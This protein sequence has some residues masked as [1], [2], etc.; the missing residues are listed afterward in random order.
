MTPEETK[1][2]L[3]S[4]KDYKQRVEYI[5][6]K[7]LNVHSYDFKAVKASNAPHKNQNDYIVMKDKYLNKMHEIIKNI[8]LLENMKHRSV[9]FY[10]Y[11]ELMNAYEVADLIGCSVASVYAYLRESIK[12]LG[13]ILTEPL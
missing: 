8:E 12:E 10:R 6:N 5:E 11:I 13:K 1:T 3:E 7:V 2:Y 9:L 4:Y